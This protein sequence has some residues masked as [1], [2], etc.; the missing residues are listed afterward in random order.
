MARIEVRFSVPGEKVFA[1]MWN[2]VEHVP[3]D[4]S[5]A[6]QQMA[7]QFFMNNEQTF[8]SEGP[9]WKPL[10]LKYEKWKQSRYPGLPILVRTGALKS[11]LT[12]RGASGQVL[13]IM[14]QSMEIGTSIRYAMY[15][16]TGNIK[17]DNFPPG[18]HP[19]K[20]SPVIILAELRTAWQKTITAVLREKFDYVG[21]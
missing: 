4:M 3:D 9:G 12:K 10:S 15:H 16:Q 8:D 2:A 20:R 11:S 6:F 17:S 19:P 21:E 7:D 5:E 18:T 1:R 13:R 14:P